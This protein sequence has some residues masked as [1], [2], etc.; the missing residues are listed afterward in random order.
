MQQSRNIANTGSRLADVKQNDNGENAARLFKYY[1]QFNPRNC[2][3]APIQLNRVSA[4]GLYI[5]HKKAFDD[6]YTFF[7]AHSLDIGRYVEFFAKEQMRPEE[8]IDKWLFSKQSI[9]DYMAKLQLADKKK[10]IYTWFNKS[11]TN[12]VNMCI[13][14]DYMSGKDCIL[15]LVRQKRLAQEF[16]TGRISKYFFAAM[17]NFKSLI[18]KLDHFSKLEF[19]ELYDK[20]DIYNTEINDV[21]IQ[22]RNRTVNPLDI[23][24]VELAKRKSS[25][26]GKNEDLFDSSL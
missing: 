22:Y 5:R 2:I 14:C 17:P 3:Y 6:L 15:D 8:D 21:F 7:S 20:F 11:V 19:S 1:S 18:P 9:S 13:E 16:M 12:I 25:M 10:K 23:V 4:H 24:D 26:R